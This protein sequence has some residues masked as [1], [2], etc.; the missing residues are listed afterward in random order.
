MVRVYVILSALILLVLN[1]FYGIFHTAN[2]WWL[3]PL[4][5][6]SFV[7][8]F[9]ILQMATFALMIL[10]TNVNKERKRSSSVFRFM[11]KISLPIIIK[12]A[13][14]EINAEG[15]EKMPEDTLVMAVCNHQ[16]DFDP[17]VMFAVFPD[18]KLAFIGKKEIYKTMPFIAKA[19]HRLDC[20]PIDRENDRAAALTIIK[21]IKTIKEG[22]ASIGIFPEGYVSKSC[23]LLPF[24]NGCFKIATKANV[25]IAVCV[26]NNTRQ[27][28]KNICRRKTVVEFRLLD[29]IY[30]EQFKDKNTAEIGDMVHKLME[31]GLQEIKQLN[32]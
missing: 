23:E 9:I 21:A 19:M 8:G 31:S 1:S 18:A 24:R 7:L 28:P 6:V 4:L 20:M 13:R 16:H 10:F 26:I 15:V 5:L 30:P 17:A 2:A 12:V 27:I 29:V 32:K 3:I 25:P 22:K 14:V 11:V